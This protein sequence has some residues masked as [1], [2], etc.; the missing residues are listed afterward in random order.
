MRAVIAGATGLVG[1]QLVVELLTDP[2]YTQVVVLT[3]RPW[4]KKHPKLKAVI[5]GDLSEIL[6][7]AHN[8]AGDVYFCCIGTT[9]KTA[10]SREAFEKVDLIAVR[11]FAEVAKRNKAKTFVLVSA[12][13][14]HPKSKIFY[15]RIKGQAEQAVEGAAPKVVIFRPSL[16]IGDR[17]EERFGEKFFI[18][19]FSLLKPVLP[20]SLANKMATS[21]QVLACRMREES[22]RPNPAGA[23]IIEARDLGVL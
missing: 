4:S 10:G 19:L 9:I 6:S 18:Q 15:S 13:G 23:K 17:A 5:I 14:A 21:V 1:S 2:T 3:R 11:D 16:L 22:L 8:L 7:H 20:Q 12:S